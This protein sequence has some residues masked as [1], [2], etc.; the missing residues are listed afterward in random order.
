[1]TA[2]GS[3]SGSHRERVKAKRREAIR[4]SGMRLFAEHGYDGTTIADIARA[5]D[6]APRTVQ[7]YFPSKHDIAL[8]VAN[9]VASRLTDAVEQHPEAGFLDVVDIWLAAEAEFNDAELMAL[10]KA[11]NEANPG[12]Q[13][14]SSSQLT[15]VVQVASARLSTETG[16]AVDEPLSAVLAAA[17]G[18]ALAQYIGIAHQ[19]RD[20]PELHHHVI[21][22]LRALIDAARATH[23]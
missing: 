14:L 12:L 5:A 10:T 18:A 1:M 17:V 9:E 23:D 13:A 15:D 21:A 2:P 7:Q 11:M 16:L 19:F 4:R 6:V 20:T 3:T 8:S 22:C